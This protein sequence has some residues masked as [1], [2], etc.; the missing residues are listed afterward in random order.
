[1]QVRSVGWVPPR[2]W[3][4]PTRSPLWKERALVLMPFELEPR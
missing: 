4:D 3:L 2:A 1:M